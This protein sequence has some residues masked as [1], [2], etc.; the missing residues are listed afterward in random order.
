MADW[1]DRAA[2]AGDP[3]LMESPAFENG[4]KARCGRC[5]VLAECRTWI[6]G[7][8]AGRS[9]PAVAAMVVAGETTAERFERRREKEA[10]GER[11]Q[12]V[13]DEDLLRG[14]LDW[15]PRRG[16]RERRCW[17]CARAFTR[18]TSGRG[19]VRYKTAGLCRGCGN[20][21]WKLA[22]EQ[23]HTRTRAVSGCLP[24]EVLARIYEG[25]VP[26]GGRLC[27]RECR[28]CERP[29]RSKRDTT[30]RAGRVT[31]ASRGMCCMC[32][33]RIRRYRGKKD[34]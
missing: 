29:M 22:K 25:E 16:P 28:G 26:P 9:L 4:A 1:K 6:D 10:G 5:P 21:A 31:H 30:G 32:M 14:Y 13:S 12:V 19:S 34:G 11:F 20:T 7:V 15:P 17:G 18:Q 24:A 3:F 23:G 27:D 2:C 33:S 8:E